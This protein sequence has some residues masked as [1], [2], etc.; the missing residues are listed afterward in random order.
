MKYAIKLG[1]SYYYDG[2]RPTSVFEH[3][4]FARLTEDGSWSP[5]IWDG[6]ER[7]TAI[8]AYWFDN[9]GNPKNKDTWHCVRGGISLGKFNRTVEEV[10]R[11]TNRVTFEPNPGP[12]PEVVLVDDEFE[13]RAPWSDEIETKVGDFEYKSVWLFHLPRGV[14]ENAPF[15]SYPTRVGMNIPAYEVDGWSF[16]C[17][18]NSENGLF[19]RQKVS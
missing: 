5:T 8:I 18:V 9:N 6:P 2:F 12:F 1:D 19:R 17:M 7:P 10:D 14:S 16:V 11:G 3:E 15:I 4:G 13:G